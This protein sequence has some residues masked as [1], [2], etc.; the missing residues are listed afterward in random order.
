M[1]SW[2]KKCKCK[3]EARNGVHVIIQEYCKSCDIVENEKEMH[4]VL[5][6]HLM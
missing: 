2:K 5:V 6:K 4:E 1:R 3:Y